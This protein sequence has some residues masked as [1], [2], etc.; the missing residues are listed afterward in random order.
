VLEVDSLTGRVV[1]DA[2][3]PRTVKIIASVDRLQSSPL[4]L[5]ITKRPDS[6]SLTVT[7]DTISYSFSDTTLNFSHALTAKVLHHD[8]TTF[9]SG[10]SSWVVRYSLERASDTVFAALV[11]DQKRRLSRLPSGLYH[12]DTTAADGSAA[13]AL[14]IRPGPPLVTPLDSIAVLVEAKYRGV[15]IAGSPARIFVYVK[16]RIS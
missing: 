11:D 3:T 12:I 8:S 16:P 5:A 4:L 15:H 2:A 9:Y 7:T 1:S 14:R 10:V 6:L 13:R